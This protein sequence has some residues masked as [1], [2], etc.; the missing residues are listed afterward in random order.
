MHSLLFSSLVL[1]TCNVCHRNQCTFSKP[2]FWTLCS[3][4]FQLIWMLPP[5]LLVS[6]PRLA[7]SNLPGSVDPVEQSKQVSLPFFQSAR[8]AFL[9]LDG[10]S[11]V[12][13]A[14]QGQVLH[15][16]APNRTIV[17]TPETDSTLVFCDQGAF[18]PGLHFTLRA[19][20]SCRSVIPDVF[21]RDPWHFPNCAG[22][23]V[24]SFPIHATNCSAVQSFPF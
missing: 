23:H 12:Q 5:P 16:V 20:S 21:V 7:P 3:G 14:H 4:P 18:C 15:T 13:G 17:C 24:Q 19:S 9:V 11:I 22:L 10:A 1:E 8:N 6:S 2:A